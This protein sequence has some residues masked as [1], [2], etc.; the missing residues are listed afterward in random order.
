MKV[1][2]VK[3]GEFK[4]FSQDMFPKIKC[5]SSAINYAFHINLSFVYN[6]HNQDHVL[7]ITDFLLLHITIFSRKYPIVFS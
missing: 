6:V 1:Y 7:I 2:E 4:L 3:K 5:V